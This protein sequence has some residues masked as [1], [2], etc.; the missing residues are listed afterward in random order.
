MDRACLIASSR[1][2]DAATQSPR[3]FRTVVDQRANV[4]LGT[5]WPMSIGP[6]TISTAVVTVQLGGSSFARH[7]FTSD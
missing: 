2:P 7:V 1:A 5:V 3:L 6:G 4:D